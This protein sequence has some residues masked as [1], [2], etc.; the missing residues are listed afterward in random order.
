MLDTAAILPYNV[1]G[2][3][4][5]KPAERAGFG[6]KETMMGVETSAPVLDREAVA[7]VGDPHAGEIRRLLGLSRRDFSRLAGFSERAIAG[8]ESGERPSAQSR[9]RL[10]EIQQFQRALAAVMEAGS[11]GPWLLQPNSAF[12][13]LKPL[14]V[15]ERGEIH[16]IWRMIFYLQSGVPG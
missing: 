3:L 13:G 16:R 15:I 12:Q 5:L 14:E 11:I 6:K 7:A 2:G 1:G 8:W 10:L 4:W 9:Q